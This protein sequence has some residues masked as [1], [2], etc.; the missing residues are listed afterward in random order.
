VFPAAS[1]EAL[2]LLERFLEFDSEKRISA[3]EALAHP[4]M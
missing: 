3:Q 4:F 1:D 2:D